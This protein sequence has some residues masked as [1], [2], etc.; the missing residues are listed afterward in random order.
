MVGKKCHVGDAV[1]RSI[2]LILMSVFAISFI[3]AVLWMFLSSFRTAKQFSDAPLKIWQINFS[4]EN[5]ATAFGY[6]VGK[7]RTDMWGMLY[8][9]GII[10]LVSTVLS[11]F[12]P[13]I[14]GYVGAKYKFR[15][16]NALTTMV[17]ISMI[18]PSIGA[19][20]AT[21][22]FMFSLNL[23]DTYF[24]LFLMGAGGL[25]FSF[26]LYRNYFAA[27]P[28]DYAEAAFIDGAGNMRTF[29]SIMLPQAKP[30][31]VSLAIVHAI[32]TWNDYFTPYMYLPSHP[33]VA[34]GVQLVSVKAGI[35]Y[36]VT[37]AIMSFMT[38]V[39]LVVYAFFSKT[40]M[41]SVSAGGV[42]G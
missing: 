42:K 27:I 20:T 23:I 29:L 13:G 6:K 14:T 26:L 31:I 7:N 35:N 18:V 40:I 22:K 37:F 8:N 11:T 3:F 30:I 15:G 16:R 19:L 28:W 9:S 38:I 12:I 32:G 2:V 4:F 34:Y 39:V 24:G 33:T 10:I 17:F 1:F 21:Y 5:Y 41:E 36:P 25:G